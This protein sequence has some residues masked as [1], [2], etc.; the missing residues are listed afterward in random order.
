ML[1]A[2]KLVVAQVNAQRGIL[3]GKQL[4]TV[5]AGTF[6]T[7]YKKLGGVLTADLQHDEK[8][9]TFR[10]ELAPLAKNKPQALVLIAFAGASGVTMVKEALEGGFF[11]QFVG[12]DSLRDKILIEQ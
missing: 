5:T 2:A 3:A 6:R 12:T 4:A 7:A 1:D 9:K 11:T 10:T 8:K